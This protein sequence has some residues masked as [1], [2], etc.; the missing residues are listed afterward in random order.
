MLGWRAGTLRDEVE[1]GLAIA[2][3][4]IALVLLAVIVIGPS[5][6]VRAESKMPME[7]QVRLLLGL[8]DETGEI[9]AV[10]LD[11][12]GPTPFDTGQFT[13]LTDLNAP[14][15]PASSEQSTGAA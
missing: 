4:V 2:V 14:P 12:H 3:V 1:I 6:R 11:D 15:E 7:T 10:T 5:R 13:A 9:R 8:S